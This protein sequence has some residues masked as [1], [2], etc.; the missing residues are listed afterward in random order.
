MSNPKHDRQGV[1]KASDIE[2]KYD[3]SL[4]KDVGKNARQSEKLSQL[5]QLVSQF[6]VRTNNRLEKLENVFSVG[7]IYTTLAESDPADIFGGE[8]EL[9][10]EGN[11]LVGVVSESE[12]P[13]LFQGNDKCFI[14]KRIA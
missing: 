10:A 5:N 9:I 13:E 6:I 12:L 3:L 1:R 4:L 2:Q 7:S 11:I 8:W 14:W